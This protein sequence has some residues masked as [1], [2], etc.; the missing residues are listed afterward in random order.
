[1]RLP[2]RV[3]N[4]TSSHEI[5]AA[6]ATFARDRPDALFVVADPLFTGRR[7]Q[8]TVVRGFVDS[9]QCGFRWRGQSGQR[10][11]TGTPFSGTPHQPFWSYPGLA[12]RRAAKAAYAR[13]E[14]AIEA[15]FRAALQSG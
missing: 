6:F 8:L 3:V 11:Q 13:K 14:T 15:P 4:A 2:I 7:V 10:G 5:N 1:M 9:P 12:S